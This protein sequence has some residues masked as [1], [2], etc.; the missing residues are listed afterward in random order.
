MKVLAPVGAI[1]NSCIGSLF[2]KESRPHQNNTR[3]WPRQH[4]TISGQASPGSLPTACREVLKLLASYPEISS[5]F[6]HRPVIQKTKNTTI[7]FESKA[8]DGR[9]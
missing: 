6:H 5:V 1:M 3:P 2:L 8:C 9:R 4:D 7:V